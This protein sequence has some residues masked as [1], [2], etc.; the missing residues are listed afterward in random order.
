MN[1]R[2]NAQSGMTYIEILVVVTISVITGGLLLTIMANSSSL[3][4]KQSFIVNQGLGVNDALASVKKGIKEA[5]AVVSSYTY[6]ST[7]YNSSSAQLILTVSALDNNGNLIPNTYDYF[8][9]L[10]D[11]KILRLKIFPDPLSQRQQADRVLA[12]NLDQVNF[13]YYN[14][15]EPPIE[16]APNQAAKVKMTLSLQQKMGLVTQNT[17]ATAEANLR[18]D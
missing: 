3:F 11:Q 7:T 4:F 9:Y 8:V 16:V 13:Q 12:T 2:I 10:K 6:D 15:A 14:S 5:K 17:V 1:S 18:N